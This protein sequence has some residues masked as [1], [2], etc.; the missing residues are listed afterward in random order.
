M[1]DS[2]QNQNDNLSEY[3]AF[4]M[5]LLQLMGTLALIGLTLGFGLTW[6]AHI[7]K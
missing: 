4:G 3:R 6:L 2:K 1:N 5:S 7:F